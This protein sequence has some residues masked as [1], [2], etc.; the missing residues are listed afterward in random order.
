MVP[1]WIQHPISTLTTPW[2]DLLVHSVNWPSITSPKCRWNRK[3]LCSMP[4]PIEPQD[5][6]VRARWGTRAAGGRADNGI[7]CLTRSG[8]V[9]PPDTTVSA[10]LMRPRSSGHRL[11]RI[12][13]PGDIDRQQ[14]YLGQLQRGRELSHFHSHVTG[15]LSGPWHLDLSL[16]LFVSL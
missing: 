10:N 13:G 12:R 8:W 15:R 3:K 1:G 2:N 5:M 16:L 7:F 11:S 4:E 9:C 14:Q 6:D